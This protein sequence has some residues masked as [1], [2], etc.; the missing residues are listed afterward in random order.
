MPRNLYERVEVMF[1]VKDGSLR[2]R[3]FDEILETYLRDNDKTRTLRADGSYGRAH[4]ASSSRLSRNGHHF[5]AQAFFIDLAG[6]QSEI[7]SADAPRHQRVPGDPLA[8][9]A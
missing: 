4:P 7:E 2:K 9:S 5:S 6:G 3:I 8:E 1:P